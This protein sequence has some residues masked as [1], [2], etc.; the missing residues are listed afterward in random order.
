VL[1]EAEIE[2]LKAR[3]LIFLSGFFAIYMSSPNMG[4]FRLRNA[5]EVVVNITTRI[6]EVEKTQIDKH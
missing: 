2:L 6:V 4:V 5:M 3:L 1:G